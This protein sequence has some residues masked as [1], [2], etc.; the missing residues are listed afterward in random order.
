VDYRHFYHTIETAPRP[1]LK[2]YLDNG[3]PCGPRPSLDEIRAHSEA[4]L[5]TFD[6]TYKRLL[7]PHIYKVSITEKLRSL[8]MKLMGVV[9]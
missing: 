6:P 3:E 4:D 5:E 8:K 1:L 7:K 2:L 9:S